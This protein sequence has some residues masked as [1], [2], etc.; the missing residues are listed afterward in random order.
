M[1][2]LYRWGFDFHCAVD[3]L[4]SKPPTGKQRSLSCLPCL[5]FRTLFMFQA[6]EN[7]KNHKVNKLRVWALMSLVDRSY[8]LSSWLDKKDGTDAAR[9]EGGQNSSN[10]SV[11]VYPNPFA[12][13][14]FYHRHQPWQDA[15]SQ[16]TPNSWESCLSFQWQCQLK[17]HGKSHAAQNW[18][19][20]RGW[21]GGRSPKSN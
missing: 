3:Y 7:E 18:G 1:F 13:R 21:G 12:L 5:F 14:S 2:H 9:H 20:G 4:I 16:Q 10:Y 11:F 19:T 6:S 8:T 17:G 15:P